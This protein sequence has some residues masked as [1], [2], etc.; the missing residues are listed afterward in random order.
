MKLR[1]VCFFALGL[2][3]VPLI[4]GCP[5]SAPVPKKNGEEEVKEGSRE[6]QLDVA[7]DMIRQADTSKEYHDALYVLNNY[8]NKPEINAK[9]Q[10]ADEARAFLEQKAGLESGELKEVEATSF[11]PLDAHHL[12]MSFLLRDAAHSLEVQG[13]APLEQARHCFGW[14]MRQVYLLQAPADFVPPH[15]VLRQGYATGLDRALAFLALLRQLN[16][17]G[18]IVRPAGD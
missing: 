12:E 4:V 16:L 6:S 8:C 1:V 7:C 17:P 5:R 10:I 2:V 14:V 11:T 3:L 9:L 15:L 18:C 13:L